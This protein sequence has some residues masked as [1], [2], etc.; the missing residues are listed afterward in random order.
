MNARFLLKRYSTLLN[1]TYNSTRLKT[2]F[3]K[4]RAIVF[5]LK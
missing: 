5:T 2:Q 3:E 4:W 1:L